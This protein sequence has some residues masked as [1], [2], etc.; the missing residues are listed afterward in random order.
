M[1][2]NKPKRSQADLQTAHW[3]F[4]LGFIGLDLF[5]GYI[6]DSRAAFSSGVTVT[7][8]GLVFYKQKTIINLVKLKIRQK[9]S[10]LI[11]YCIGY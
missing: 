8:V 4:F 10:H 11:E 3:Y 5:F 1:W 2:K 7:G 9:N 6:I